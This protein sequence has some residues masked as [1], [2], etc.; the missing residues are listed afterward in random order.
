MKKE[1]N[2]QEAINRL[3]ELDQNASPTPWEAWGAGEG[4]NTSIEHPMGN[5]LERDQH[6]SDHMWEVI[7]WIS[8]ADAD[9]IVETRNALPALLTEIERLTAENQHLTAR[10]EESKEK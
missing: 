5:V 9:L 2:I 8:E 3:R 7:T 10:M 1:T 6:G 4:G